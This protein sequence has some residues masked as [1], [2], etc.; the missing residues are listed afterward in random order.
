MDSLEEKIHQYFEA[1]REVAAKLD[2]SRIRDIVQA[3]YNAWEQGK[4]VFVMGN[5]GSAGTASHFAADLT[6]YPTDQLPAPLHGTVKRLQAISLVENPSLMTSII[7][8]LGFE[9]LFVEQLRHY[10]FG[11]GDVLVAIS[12]HGGA[13]RDRAGAWSQNLLKAVDYAKQQGGVV[14]GLSGFD[15]G[16]LAEEAHHVLVVPAHST[17]LVES[18]H[19]VVHHIIIDSLRDLITEKVKQKES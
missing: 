2:R 3:L 15:G 19:V 11:P 18:F 5:G 17:P 8:D 16:M 13:G 9:N 14:V 4:R 10:H 12:V 7:N 1:S 6:K